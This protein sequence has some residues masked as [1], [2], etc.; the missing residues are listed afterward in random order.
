MTSTTRP[1]VR[2]GAASAPSSPPHRATNRKP[3]STKALRAKLRKALARAKAA[4]DRA[5]VAQAAHDEVVERSRWSRRLSLALAALTLMVSI[6]LGWAWRERRSAQSRVRALTVELAA[7]RQAAKARTALDEKLT[8]AGIEHDALL[9]RR[10]NDQAVIAAQGAR[11]KD[12]QTDNAALR[13]KIEDL[14]AAARQ[15]AITS[16]QKQLRTLDEAAVGG[17]RVLEPYPVL[18]GQERAVM[19]SAS[20]WARER[21]LHLYPQMGMGGFLRP[22]GRRADEILKTFN[23]KRSDFVLCGD[24]ARAVLVVEHHGPGHFQ[25]DWEIRDQVKRRLLNMARVG[26]IITDEHDDDTAI[27]RRLNAAMDDPEGAIPP[28]PEVA[29]K[30][31]SKSRAL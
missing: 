24:D 30:H 17:A 26:L 28:W 21:N 22:Q 27:R 7:A 5:E 2:A 3:V 25:E 13:G 19:R 10:R 6:A 15:R 18:N 1:Q 12:L 29:S 9:T 16:G 11:I 20:A 8:Q 14:E 23:S 31:G 4:E